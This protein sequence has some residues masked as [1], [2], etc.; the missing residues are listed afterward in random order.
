MA[1]FLL[2]THKAKDSSRRSLTVIPGRMLRLFVEARW[3][4]SQ[5]AVD[6]QHASLCRSYRADSRDRARGLTSPLNGYSY[7]TV[8]A[9]KYTRMAAVGGH[10]WKNAAQPTRRRPAGHTREQSTNWRN[11]RLPWTDAHGCSCYHGLLMALGTDKTKIWSL[12]EVFRC[13]PGTV[14]FSL[15]IS[16]H[17]ILVGRRSGIEFSVWTHDVCVVLRTMHQQLTVPLS[18][19]MQLGLLH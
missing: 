18:E 2:K 13:E 5:R 10:L 12:C 19:V 7:G 15:S 14:P 16:T 8:L 17:H 11:E 3:P 9:T 4:P 6:P 1:P